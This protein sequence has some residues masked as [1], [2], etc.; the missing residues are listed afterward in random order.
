[1]AFFSLVIAHALPMPCPALPCPALPKAPTASG[2][3]TSFYALN[4]CSGWL[5]E[6]PV[7][8]AL[9]EEVPFSNEYAKP[10]D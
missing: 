3:H 7:K 6:Q 4:H 2:Y 9:I 8:M 10:P 5:N 1:V